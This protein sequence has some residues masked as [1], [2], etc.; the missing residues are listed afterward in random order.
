VGRRLVGDAVSDSRSKVT[1]RRLYTRPVTGALVAME[2]RARRFPKGLA[3]FITARDQTCRTPYCDAPIR[4]IDHAEPWHREGTTSAANGLGMCERCNYVK[5]A[6]G[7][8]VS[9][10]GEK[11]GHAAAF[12]TPTGTE[13]RSTAPPGPGANPV[14]V[15]RVEAGVAKVVGG[16]RAA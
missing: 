12:V 15:S 7:W 14:T 2:S 8:R 11:H 9:A 1:L 13:Y 4:H 5:E 16:L 3:A 10:A 6:P